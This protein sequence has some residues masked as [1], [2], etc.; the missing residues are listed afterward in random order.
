MGKKN[1]L[2]FSH[3]FATQFIDISNQYTQLFDRSQYEIT[4]VYLVGEPDAEARL[5]HLADTVIFLNIKASS[6]R[7]LK[8]NPIKKMRQLQ[9]EKNFHIVICHRYKPSYI[10]LWVAKFQKI[11]LL[12]CVMHELGTMKKFSRRLITASLWNKN[13]YFAGVSD[14]VRDDM[15]GDL[16]RVPD[17][18]ILTL[19]NVIDIDLTEPQIL[20]KNAARALLNLKDEHFIF[21]NIGRL[22]HAKNQSAL[23]DAFALIKPK[24]PDAKLI[25]IGS[26]EL[27]SSIA[28]KVRDLNLE[29]DVILTGFIPQA[30]RFMR[31]FDVF[32]LNSSKEAFGRVLL[33]A[34]LAKT[35]I[36]ATKIH[37]IPEV[38]GGSGILI[39]ANHS[40]QL[41][42]KMLELY[43]M[44]K[45]QLQSFTKHG[46][47]R[48]YKIFSTK[49]FKEIFWQL[50]LLQNEGSV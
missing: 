30:F 9:R 24:C 40:A 42:Y 19:H 4:V 33:E 35:P 45:T 39:D 18:H 13:V 34:M 5:R 2:I 3:G 50:P 8:I 38:I 7:Y 49:H 10:M 27:A 21:G 29:H 25:I 32:I 26:G 37:G 22:A 1:I 17:S 6:T 47:D 16:W 41:A 46:Y 43:Q 15:R 20:T 28:L 36:I 23:I 11:P 14:A 31:A 12:F 44:D 48:A